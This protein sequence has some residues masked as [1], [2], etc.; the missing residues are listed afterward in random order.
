MLFVS[1][2]TDSNT[3]FIYV[4]IFLSKKATY[5]SNKTSGTRMKLTPLQEKMRKKLEGSKF[6]MINEMLYKNT[7]DHAYSV[8]QADPSLFSIVI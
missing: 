4:F 7:G 6:R 8:F 2:C 5:Y 3:V 1:V